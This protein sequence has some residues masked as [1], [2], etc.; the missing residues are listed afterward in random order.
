MHGVGTSGAS[1][2]K[3]TLTSGLGCHTFRRNLNIDINYKK[4]LKTEIDN[5]TYKFIE[6]DKLSYR[7]F[8][9]LFES[10][11]RTFIRHSYTC[12]RQHEERTKVY[13]DT[14]ILKNSALFG[15]I[16]YVANKQLTMMIIP[17]G[18]NKNMAEI[19]LLVI[20]Q[21]NKSGNVIQN[22]A[23]TFISNQT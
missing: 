20:Y 7:E 4:V 17:Q 6:E 19:S 3:R 9:E 11:L 12:R 10:T 2:C 22:S 13:T 14:A 5:K 23:H 16:Y 8:I 21:C 18:L 15:S 1:T